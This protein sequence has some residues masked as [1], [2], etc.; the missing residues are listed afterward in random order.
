MGNIFRVSDKIVSN[1]DLYFIS[2]TVGNDPFIFEDVKIP[3]IIDVN[4]EI[5][6]LF[7]EQFS[8]FVKLNNLVGNNYQR[9]LYYPQMGLNFVAGINVSL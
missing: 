8:A 1:L 2:N 5:T 6:Y 7:S 3:A 4:A 9:F